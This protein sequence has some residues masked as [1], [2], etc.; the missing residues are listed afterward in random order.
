MH[1]KYDLSSLVGRTGQHLVRPP[2]FSER[3][4]SANLR[5]QLTAIEQARECAQSGRGDVYQEEHCTKAR[6]LWRWRN[7]RH[8]DAARL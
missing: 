8:E 6:R 2:G 5:D 3:E 1:R 7:H 4:Q